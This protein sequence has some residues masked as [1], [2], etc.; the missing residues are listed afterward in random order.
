MTAE[1]FVSQ[2]YLV[3]QHQTNLN[4]TQVIPPQPETIDSELHFKFP[5][6]PDGYVARDKELQCEVA[7]T[8]Q[9]E[10][11]S[12]HAFTRVY[13]MGE[14]KYGQLGFALGAN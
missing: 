14:T 6:K 8:D 13:V 2:S 11:A 9:T 7:K 4:S 10:R 1:R 12:Q 3:S 5:P